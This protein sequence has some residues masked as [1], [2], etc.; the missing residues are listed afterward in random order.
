MQETQAL[1]PVLPKFNIMVPYEQNPRFI[2]RVELLR[3]LHTMLREEAPRQHN[4]RVALYGIGG[5]G[6]TQTAVAYVYERQT[7]YEGIY[8]INAENE[9]SLHLGFNAIAMETGC[10]KHMNNSDLKSLAKAVLMWLKQQRS[11][12]VV[13]DNLDQIELINGLLPHRSPG[14]HTLITTRNPNAI[15]IPA[16]G[17]EVTPPNIREAADMLYTL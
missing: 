2:G 1:S 8:W 16:R 6:K 10:A 4:H 3:T 9:A 14:Q 11:W 17:L 15:G 13:I 12:L 7:E 5:V